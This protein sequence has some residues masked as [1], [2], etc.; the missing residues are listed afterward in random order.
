MTDG[1]VLA[2]AGGKR[3]MTMGVAIEAG[4]HPYQNL[5]WLLPAAL[6][7]AGDDPA[8]DQAL[9]P[10]LH[11]L[12]GVSGGAGNREAWTEGPGSGLEG[13]MLRAMLFTRLLAHVGMNATIHRAYG[14]A[15]PSDAD[16]RRAAGFWR[17]TWRRC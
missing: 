16:W 12:V 13:T 11:Y 1:P 9:E 10:M 4:S 8:V 2:T 3:M 6:L 17:C 5:M 15:A 14:S 7:V